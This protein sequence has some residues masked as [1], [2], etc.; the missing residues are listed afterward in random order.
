M[1]DRTLI[2]ISLAW[3]LIGIFALILIASY[4][5]P[6]QIK[7]KDLES[8]V[9]KTVLLQ[10]EVLKVSAAESAT[11]ID[12]ADDSGKITVVAFDKVQNITERNIVTVK[13]KV[14]IYKGNLELIASEIYCVKC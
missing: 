10:G 8:N 12:L 5:A 7:I 6:E 4:S 11:F 14:Q 1:D 3:S 13:G 9:G 2:K